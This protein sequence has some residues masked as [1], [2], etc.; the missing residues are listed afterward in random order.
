VFRG[1][2]LTSYLA[3]WN[4]YGREN[5][6]DYYWNQVDNARD[7]YQQWGFLPVI[8]LEWKF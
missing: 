8:E 7:T 1:S 5:V 4:A 2:V 6:A 3:L